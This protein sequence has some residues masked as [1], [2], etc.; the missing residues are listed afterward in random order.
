MTITDLDSLFVLENGFSK[1]LP[2]ITENSHI[3]VSTDFTGSSKFTKN[4]YVNSVDDEMIVTS[5][6]YP[7]AGHS[8]QKVTMLSFMITDKN[9]QDIISAFDI[10]KT[11]TI[12]IGD[13]AVLEVYLIFKPELLKNFQV[14]FPN[15]FVKK[16]YSVVSTLD[17]YQTLISDVFEANCQK[18][19]SG[20]NTKK[21]LVNLEISFCD[22]KMELP[23]TVSVYVSQLPTHPT[24]KFY[25]GNFHFY[26]GGITLGNLTCGVDDATLQTMKAL[27][28]KNTPKFRKQSVANRMKK[29]Y[30]E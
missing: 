6:S 27:G 23:V 25:N 24:I 19:Q 1:F 20:T 22:W 3:R 26:V 8:N 29:Y 16:Y 15:N 5:I 4:H 21:S 18:Q 17:K 2:M 7:A 13:V 30:G 14:K 10:K 9:I 28:L 12:S 11:Q